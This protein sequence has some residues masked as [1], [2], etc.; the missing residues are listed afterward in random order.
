MPSMINYPPANAGDAGHVDSGLGSQRSPGG[1]NGSPRQDSCLG[2]PMDRGAWLAIVR[3][4]SES[5][6]TERVR[7][8]THTHTIHCMRLHL[9]KLEQKVPFAGMVK[10]AIKLRKPMS[11]D[12]VGGS[13]ALELW[14]A[15][16]YSLQEN[17]GLFPT[18]T[19]QWILPK[20]WEP[21]GGPSVKT[22]RRLQPWLT[23]GCH[24]VRSWGRAPS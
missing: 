15:F 9:M 2:N 20:T 16:G 13:W 14:G 12:T 8:H 24:A 1:G 18:A 17:G 22:L 3:G 6:T 23:P 19:M 11:Q 4:V 7:T 10:W 5:D 21:A